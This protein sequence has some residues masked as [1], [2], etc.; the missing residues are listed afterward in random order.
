MK[1]KINHPE[2]Y[3]GIENQFEVIKIIEHYNLGFHLGNVLKYILR[4]GVKDQDT[5][6]QDLEKARWYIERKIERLKEDDVHDF[7][8]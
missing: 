2:Y 8:M 5:E 1:E 3:G 4:A 6:I 7:S